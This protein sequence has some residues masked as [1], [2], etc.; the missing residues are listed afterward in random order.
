MTDFS[1]PTNS[2]GPAVVDS[3]I[4]NGFSPAKP[5]PSSALVASGRDEEED[6]TIKCIC[7]F[8]DDDG[9]TVLCE[10]CETWQH[11]E[12]YYFEDGEVLDVSE[13]EHYCAD[14]KPRRLDARGA[15]ERQTM[16]R[17]QTDPGERRVKK[18]TTKSHK[19]K[20]KPPDTHAALTN[21][22]SSYER[23]YLHGLFDRS[24]ESPREYFPFTKRPKITHKHSGSLQ[25]PNVSC[26]GNEKRSGSA[27]RATHSPSKT[28]GNYPTD[29]YLSERY[30][31]EFMHLYDD[32]PGDATMQANLFNDITITRSLS[33]WT[34]DAEALAQASNGLS[35]Q[36]I[37][38][39]CEQPLNSMGFPFLRK[40]CKQGDFPD[41]NG[42]CPQW[43]FLTTDASLVKGSIVGELKGKIGHMQDYVQ[44]IA[45]RWDYLRH[46]VPFVFFHPKLPIYIDTRREGTKCRYLR[47]SCRPNLRMT[48]ILE[49]GSD[50]RFCFVA[51]DDLEAGTE[52][53]IGWTLDQHIRNFFHRRNT[54]PLGNQG[55]NDAD[56]DYV[57]D[58]VGK[59]L[60][61][62]GGCACDSPAECS[63]A[64]YDRRS[65]PALNGGFKLS[66]GNVPKGRNGYSKRLSPATDS[67]THGGS[68]SI[69]QQEDDDDDRS[70]SGSLRSKQRS[71][72]TTPTRNQAR[73]NPF[74]VGLELSDREKRK[75]AAL[76]R[77]FEQIE[78]DKHQP[79]QKKKKRHSG[80]SS[81]QTPAN[82]G[83]RQQTS[84]TSFSQPNTPAV[85]V[86]P[87]YTDASTSRRTSGSPVGKPPLT[88]STPSVKSTGRKKRISHAR[89][90]PSA[91]TTARPHYVSTSTQTDPDY[92][93]D[94][95]N[96]PEPNKY[97]KPFMSLSR[98][99]LLRSQRERIRMEQRLQAA[100]AQQRPDAEAPQEPNGNRTAPAQLEGDVEMQDIQ[101]SI[102]RTGED[103]T[104]H[105]PMQKPRPPDLADKKPDAVEAFIKP[106]SS[107]SFNNDHLLADAQMQ[108]PP[109]APQLNSDVYAP[110]QEII[111]SPTIVRAPPIHTPGTYPSLFPS[112]SRMVQPSP[113]KKKYSLVEY[114]NRL[115]DKAEP[116][117]NEE[118]PPNS[119]PVLP[120]GMFK[121]QSG[122][123]E[124]K[125]VKEEGSPIVDT[126]GQEDGDPMEGIKQP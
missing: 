4:V 101:Q 87:Q 125:M 65:S 115:K 118:K 55:T 79:G 78:Q 23:T 68:L 70:T 91:P 120:H 83:P 53:T 72:E 89:P 12:C 100:A 44:D 107:L 122:F 5:V 34:Q 36:D 45:N 26:G 119:S 93:A 49:N 19:K 111:Q 113:V 24:A 88:T 92:R 3:L 9:N 37:F 33:L 112:S 46:P 16:R 30:S 117:A 41:V 82:S 95:Y 121:P 108:L 47:R 7:G 40:E 17:E 21:G 25:S 81:V 74:G 28:P 57:S 67:T 56:E 66:N 90:T 29:E 2:Q 69:K 116:T 58:W 1:L 22:S 6:Y 73:G 14:C 71:R 20:V 50:Y 62:F 63:F 98:Q 80:G 106:P 126:P 52:L 109:P 31:H 8:H 51:Q 97:R 60:A 35:P 39:R 38:H 84:V 85:M 64:K 42:R 124:V 59:V 48:T 123:D 18:A 94:W 114:M 96:V 13:I 110:P 104:N 61:D 43:I 76:E 77:N 86:G 105:S 75:I 103:A 27:P 99:L 10:H 15:T 11:T 32:D 54:E 102:S